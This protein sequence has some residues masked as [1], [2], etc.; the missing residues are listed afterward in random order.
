MKTMDLSSL[1]LPLSVSSPVAFFPIHLLSIEAAAGDNK[2]G[3]GVVSEKESER[4]GGHK[5]EKKEEGKKHSCVLL[6]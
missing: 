5:E 6:R 3:E 4:E 1:V 2:L